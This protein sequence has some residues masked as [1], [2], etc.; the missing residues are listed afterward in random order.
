M[1]QVA[2]V[3]RPRMLETLE[4]LLE[5]PVSDLEMALTQSCNLVAETLRADKVDAFLYDAAKDSL[6]AL[7]TSTQPMSALQKKLGLDVLPISN[8]GRVVHVFQ[9]GQ[10]FVTGHLDRDPEELRGPKFALNIRSK[11]GVP[12]EVGGRRRG[13]MMIASHQPE[14]FSA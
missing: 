10:T 11:V 14:Y 13:M 9:T 6:V 5:I 3:P 4:Q 2:P 1:N 7:G 8:G 12:L